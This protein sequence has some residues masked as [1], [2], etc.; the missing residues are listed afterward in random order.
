MFCNI[1]FKLL[2]KQDLFRVES[3]AMKH[4]VTVNAQFIVLANKNPR[5]MR[6]VNKNYATFDG[7]VPFVMVCTDRQESG[8]HPKYWYYND[9]PLL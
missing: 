5:F 9:R 1:D 4:I 2:N 8:N 6:I 7:E 3:S